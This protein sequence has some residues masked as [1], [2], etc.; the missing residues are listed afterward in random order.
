MVN[1]EI[2]PVSVLPEGVAAIPVSL[3][4]V[5]SGD[6]NASLTDLQISL[7]AAPPLQIHQVGV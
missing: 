6:A 5:A 4:S 7:L 2:G 1:V 3:C